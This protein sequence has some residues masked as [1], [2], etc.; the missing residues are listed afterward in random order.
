MYEGK[1]KRKAEE[2]ERSHQGIPLNSRPD[3]NKL[4]TFFIGI[5][6]GYVYVVNIKRGMLKRRKEWAI[7]TRKSGIKD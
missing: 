5:F 6:W 3:K 4:N 2:Q 1:C 7:E